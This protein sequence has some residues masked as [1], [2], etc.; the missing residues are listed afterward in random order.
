MAIDN[1]ITLYKK[2]LKN[3]IKFNT[4]VKIENLLYLSENLSDLYQNH[5]CSIAN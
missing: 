1:K 2:K 5:L 4:E 3:E